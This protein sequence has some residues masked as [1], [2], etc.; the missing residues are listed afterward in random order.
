MMI[1]VTFYENNA[2]KI[3]KGYKTDNYLKYNIINGE[4]GKISFW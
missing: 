1:Y 2:K 3:K 4:S